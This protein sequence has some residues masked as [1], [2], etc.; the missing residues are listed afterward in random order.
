MKIMID[1]HKVGY[2][3]L[4]YYDK[5]II[6]FFGGILTLGHVLQFS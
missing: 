3:F 1:E 4:E 6:K 2:K 5:K